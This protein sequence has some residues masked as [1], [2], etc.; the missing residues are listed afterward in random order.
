[1]QGNHADFSPVLISTKTQKP[2][3]EARE[4][5]I[6]PVEMDGLAKKQ[7]DE[8]LSKSKSL[9]DMSLK[10]RAILLRMRRTRKKKPGASKRADA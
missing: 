9:N 10:L 3:D 8:F 6:V 4:G 5:E 7:S 2:E 1:M